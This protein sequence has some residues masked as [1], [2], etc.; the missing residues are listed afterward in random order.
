LPW[1]LDEVW[2]VGGASDTSHT[3][4]HLLPA[5]L[6]TG[7]Q[8]EIYVL[9]GASKRIQV[10]TD[11]GHLVTSIGREGGGPGELLEPRSIGVL[12]DGTIG[13]W[14]FGHGGIVSWSVDGIPLDLLRGPQIEDTKP[15]WAM[16]SKGCRGVMA[17]TLEGRRRHTTGDQ[18]PTRGQ[19]GKLSQ[20]RFFQHHSLSL[21]FSS[22]RVE[23]TGHAY[24]REQQ[25]GV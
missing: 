19:G 23:C 10:L 22:P 3:L 5:H 20:L 13:V 21:V 6:A 8:G 15:D 14:D 7:N 17:T 18:Q 1:V 24:S 12:S 16:Q 4:S 9:D 2:R 11:S 25:R